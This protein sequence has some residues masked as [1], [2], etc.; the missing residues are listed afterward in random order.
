MMKFELKKIFL[1]PVNRILFIILVLI[2][3]IA[4]ILTVKDVQY[5]LEMVMT[6]MELKLHAP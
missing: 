5:I 6:Y 3:V 1:K 2:T 4:G